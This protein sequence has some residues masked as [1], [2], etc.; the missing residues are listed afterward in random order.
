MA[1]WQYS[2]DMNLECGGFYWLDEGDEDFVTA[3]EVVPCSDAGGPDNLFLIESGTIFL[4]K[5]K[6]ESIL[7]VIGMKP[8]EASRNDFIYAA[9]AYYGIESEWS[10]VVQIGKAQEPYRPGG[11][12]PEPDEFLRGNARL[13]RYVERHFLI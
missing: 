9:K 6:S 2:G 5:S 12:N 3:V 7:S 13:I 11:W 4:D 8:E 1:K 10:E